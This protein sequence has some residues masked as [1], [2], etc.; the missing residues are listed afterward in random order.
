MAHR[1]EE[2]LLLSFFND[3][4]LG[5]ITPD[6]KVRLPKLPSPGPEVKKKTPPQE[7]TMEN[8]KQLSAWSLCLPACRISESVQQ[9]VQLALDTLS[10]AVG[11]S[12]FWYV[13]PGDLPSLSERQ[14]KKNSFSILF[15]S[16]QLFFTVRN[17]FQL[18]YDVVPTYH[19]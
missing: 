14:H 11:S 8:S 15:S 4:S 12:T 5:Q 6:Y 17:M 7:T 13:A 3:V 19:K 9:L 10:E 1:N 16:V 2:L 18:F